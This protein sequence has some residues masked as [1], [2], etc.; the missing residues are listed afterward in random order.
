MSQTGRRLAGRR[1][2]ASAHD[3]FASDYD[4]QL[5]KANFDALLTLAIEYDRTGNRTAYDAAIEQL[6]ALGPPFFEQ[7]VPNFRERIEVFRK[8]MPPAE[9]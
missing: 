6:A 4:E 8:G 2:A 7:A 3:R 1:A 9:Q 5:R